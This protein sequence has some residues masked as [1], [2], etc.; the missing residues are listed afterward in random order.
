MD[1]A[2]QSARLR[3]AELSEVASEVASELVEQISEYSAR[4]LQEIATNS[5]IPGNET[6]AD[7]HKGGRDDGAII[8]SNSIFGISFNSIIQFAIL[9]AVGLFA[10]KYYQKNLKN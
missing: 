8:T 10:Y 5:T 6:D 2:L 4:I 7:R 9:G 3:G 1:G